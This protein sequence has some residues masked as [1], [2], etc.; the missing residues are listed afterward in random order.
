MSSEGYPVLVWAFFFFSSSLTLSAL[1]LKSLQSNLGQGE[2]VLNIFSFL[3][4]KFSFGK[5]FRRFLLLFK[6]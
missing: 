4:S 1:T 6:V 5:P 2:I 3:F